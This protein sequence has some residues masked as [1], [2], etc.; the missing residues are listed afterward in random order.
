MV[1]NQPM[2]VLPM[3]WYIAHLICH[4]GRAQHE[5][6]V[7]IPALLKGIGRSLGQR[8]KMVQWLGIVHVYCHVQ[9]LAVYENGQKAET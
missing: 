8:V 1:F 3:L 5:L 2:N 7:R 6:P 4:R 9:L